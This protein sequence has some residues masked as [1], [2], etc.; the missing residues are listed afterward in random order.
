M[1]Q[2]YEEERRARKKLEQQLQEQPE[3]SVRSDN[4]FLSDVIKNVNSQLQMTS[5]EQ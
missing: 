5:D 4:D 3:V 2:R 1:A